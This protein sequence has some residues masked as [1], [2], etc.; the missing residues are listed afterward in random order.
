MRWLLV[1]G[2]AL[3]FA[4]NA[5]AQTRKNMIYADFLK[6]P[7]AQYNVTL[8]WDRAIKLTKKNYTAGRFYL[9][10]S[11]NLL[12]TGYSFD[13]DDEKGYPASKFEKYEIALP[14]HIRFELSPNRI[15]YGRAPGKHDSDVAVFIDAGISINYLLGAHLKEDF[16]STGT[17]FSYI[18]DGPITQTASTSITAHYLT[19]NIGM[20]ISRITMMLR[21]YQPFTET[22]WTNLSTGWGMPN[23]VHSF[24]YDKWLVEP[25]Y[26]Q[27]T[28]LLCFGYS[29]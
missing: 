27:G 15:V 23:G 17:G 24:F 8:G 26:K 14:L 16:I 20:R 18:F 11:P 4:W 10:F 12:W 19:M 5:H 7:N 2:M 28:V 6:F 29:F 13:N 25:N 9:V 21:A 1:I 22:T 3:S